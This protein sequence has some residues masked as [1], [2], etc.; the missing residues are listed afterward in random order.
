M[1]TIGDQFIL[2]TSKKKKGKINQT[3]ILPFPYILNLSVTEHLTEKVLLTE[4]FQP[5]NEE[6]ILK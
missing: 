6:K 3:F 2:K 5:K 4:V 1:A